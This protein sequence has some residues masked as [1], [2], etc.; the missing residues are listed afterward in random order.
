ME[1]MKIGIH[2]CEGSFSGRWID[3]CVKKNIPYKI[4]DCYQSDIIDQLSDCDA[5]M[6]HFH[7]ASSRDVLFAKQLLYSVKASER[8][9]FPDFDTVWHFDDKV[10]QKYLLE[11]V[12]EPLVPSYVF[13]SK[14]DALKWINETSFPKVFKLRGGAGSSNVRIVNTKTDAKRLVNIAFGRGF[15]QYNKW[16][17]LKDRIKKYRKGKTTLFDVIKGF[18]RLGYT[19]KFARIAGRE[20]GY[21]YF[22][23]FIPNNDHDIRVVVIGDKAFAI[24]RMVRKNDFR[25]SGSGTLVYEKK[26][27]DDQTIQLSFDIASKL[28]TQCLAFDFVYQNGKPLIVEISYGF[29]LNGYDPCVGYWTSDMN[30][31][32]G[33]FN[34]QEWMIDLVLKE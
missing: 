7:H 13:Y 22:Q 11:A 30:W 16:E 27:F 24:K 8:K 23:D 4:V 14:S 25:A 31:H 3:Y 33:S 1:K 12:D 9:I 19:T 20:K 26:H 17:S 32:E 34:P 6:W 18:I 21:V 2:H 29:A 5:L 15:S 10:G 28:K